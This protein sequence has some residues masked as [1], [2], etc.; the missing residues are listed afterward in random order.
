MVERFRIAAYTRISVDLELDRDIAEAEKD[1]AEDHQDQLETVIDLVEQMLRAEAQS[2]I[3]ALKD[4]KEA[5]S[6]LIDAKKKAL[7]ITE[8]QLAYEK[9]MKDYAKDASKLQAQIDLLAQDWR[10]PVHPAEIRHFQVRLRLA[11][12]FLF[13]KLPLEQAQTMRSHAATRNKDL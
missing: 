5:Y 4:Q 10:T 1:Q 13:L 12:L 7:R 8:D 2:Y 9:E 11:R 3:D 6:D